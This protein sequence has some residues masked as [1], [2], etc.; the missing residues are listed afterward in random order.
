M[1]TTWH[2]PGV[3]VAIRV[4]DRWNWSGHAGFADL[5]RRRTVTQTT[6]FGA[7]SITKTFLAALVLQL[8]DEGVLSLDD[9]VARWL[10]GI[11]NAT[12]VTIRQL[13]DH[14]S[15]VDD[16]FSHVAML[17]SIGSSPRATWSVGK[18][19]GYVKKPHFKPGEGWYYS[20]TNYLLLGQVVEAATAR[21]V[22][23]LLRERFLVPLGL[24]GTFLQGQEPVP[25]DP[26]H[27]Y[28][29]TGVS[30]KV[31]DLSDGT[32]LVPF[33]SLATAIGTAGAMVTTADDLARWAEALYGRRVLS[34]GA[35][36][37]MLDFAATRA[38]KPLWPYGLGVQ[39]V[40]LRGRGSWGHSGLLSG[41]RATMRY[42]PAD[43]L[44]IVVMTNAN[45]VDP[46]RIVQALL[47]VIYPPPA[48]APTPQ[49][50]TPLPSPSLPVPGEPA[51]SGAVTSPPAGGTN[52]L[53]A[54]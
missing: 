41:F 14:T 21:S 44:T 11:R 38:L 50:A 3:Q 47:D 31:E 28:D 4:A 9:P 49:P 2:L 30:W 5:A 36:A 43:R 27:G 20:N 29:F 7:G 26:A 52:T 6:P 48:P 46:D 35:M 12:G 32:A 16:A 17:D 42:F 51:P 45:G 53:P 18:V 39:R 22:A 54:P 1:R 37:R 15:G 24:A 13:L 10:P 34:A 23:T 19:L 8:A 40:T 33:T 25:G